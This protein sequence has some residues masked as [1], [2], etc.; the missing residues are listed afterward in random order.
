MH[1]WV[2]QIIC[3]KI[4]VNCCHLS[5]TVVLPVLPNAF[6]ELCLSGCEREVIPASCLMLLLRHTVPE[7]HYPVCIML[8]VKVKQ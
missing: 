5:V 7:R 4:T 3:Y 2:L 6:G 8:Q 1:I